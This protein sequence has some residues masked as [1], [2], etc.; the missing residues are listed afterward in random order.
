MSPAYG[1]L[2]MADLM[3]SGTF[4]EDAEDLI[5]WKKVKEWLCDDQSIIFSPKVTIIR[6]S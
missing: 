3:G 5:K 4:K 6:I 1:K 2:N